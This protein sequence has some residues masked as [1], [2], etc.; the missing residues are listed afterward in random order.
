MK[1]KHLLFAS[2]IMWLSLGINAQSA[3]GEVKNG[4]VSYSVR[5]F[6]SE[7]ML[8]NHNS[9]QDPVAVI[10]LKDA[11]QRV[12]ANL[13]FYAGDVMS[14]QQASRDR[15]TGLVEDHY[16][17]DYFDLILSQLKDRALK[18]NLLY[19]LDSNTLVLQ[20]QPRSSGVKSGVK[21]KPM[22]GGK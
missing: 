2:L 6:A 9:E 15:D 20:S 14:N 1:T 3:M 11:Q 17:I 8:A 7:L 4:Q 18:H 5:S 19:D 12:C 13:Y 10:F 16:A 22:L 21:T